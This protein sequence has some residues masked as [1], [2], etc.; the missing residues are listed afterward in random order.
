MY[1][2]KARFDGK[3]II[4]LEKVPVK[5]PCDAIVTFTEPPSQGPTVDDLDQFYGRF[6]E[7]CPWDGDPV[8]VIRKLRDEW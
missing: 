6:R 2:I 5:G 3:V 4:P 1:A 7:N 8:E